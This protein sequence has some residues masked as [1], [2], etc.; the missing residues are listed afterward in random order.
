ML[1][2]RRRAPRGSRIAGQSEAPS[3]KTAMALTRR[4]E[5]TLSG[6]RISLVDVQ[7]SRRP[8]VAA[9]RPAAAQS[10]SRHGQTSA[11]R[12]AKGGRG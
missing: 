11:P 10:G 5:S 12:E 7:E 2:G 3:G 6:H 4:L 8:M 9:L 1:R